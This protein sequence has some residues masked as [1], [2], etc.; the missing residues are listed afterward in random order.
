M[1]REIF[2]ACRVTAKGRE[3]K[4]GQTILVQGVGRAGKDKGEGRRYRAGRDRGRGLKA[5]HVQGADHD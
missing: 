2:I 4:A 1:K 3:A 5:S